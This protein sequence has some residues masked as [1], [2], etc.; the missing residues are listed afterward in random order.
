M[1]MTNNTL[2]FMGVEF[3][4]P[5]SMSDLEKEYSDLTDQRKEIE[6]NPDWPDKEIS[7]ADIRNPY[8]MI[9]KKC[10]NKKVL[11][12]QIPLYCFSYNNIAKIILKIGKNKKKLGNLFTIYPTHRLNNIKFRT[13]IS[14]IS[15]NEGITTTVRN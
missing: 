11:H 4:H 1:S 2:I 12:V 5:A 3:V 8:A 15:L 9:L 14:E 6:S 13:I 10:N 7:F